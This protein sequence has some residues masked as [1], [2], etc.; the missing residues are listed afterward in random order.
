MFNLSHREYGR[1]DGVI[2]DSVPVAKFGM[3]TLVAI[4]VGILIVPGVVSAC[5]HLLISTVLGV[6]LG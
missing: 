3:S 6:S 1:V 2:S 4:L 5:R